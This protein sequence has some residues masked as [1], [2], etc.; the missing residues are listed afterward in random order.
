M[1][2]FADRVALVS[3]GG[4]G[5]GRGIA[6]RLAAEGATVVVTD[7]DASRATAVAEEIASAGGS[8]IGRPLDATA[9][10]DWTA[11]LTEIEERWSRLD[12]AILNAGRNEPGRV[13][14][15]TDESWSAQLHLSL[16]S[17][18]YGARAT[19]PLLTQGDASAIV[20]TSSIHG[21]VGFTGFPAYAAAKGAIGA[22]VRQLAVD[23]G[24]TVRVN[25]VLPGAIDT[26]LWAR[27]D[28]SFREEVCAL[29]PMAR[30]GAVSEVATAVAFLAS[31][32][33]SFI[34]G[35]NLIV[36]GG[37]TISSQQ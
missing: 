26:P 15:L 12:V 10:A 4:S 18:F 27:R 36:D 29:T 24:T 14:D 23:N 17:V 7:V 11:V 21:V 6:L 30:L 16:D 9:T 35:Q 13:E 32:D 1:S 8:A 2:R 37:R 25:A 19:L 31:S 5:I 3:A 28:A 22:L 34:T 20:V 33:A